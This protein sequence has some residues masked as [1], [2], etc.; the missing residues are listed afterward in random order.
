MTGLAAAAVSAALILWLCLGDPKRRRALRIAGEGHG[1]STRRLIAAAACLPGLACAASGDAA[2][3]LI[4]LGGSGAADVN[5]VLPQLGVQ[6]AAVAVVAV[7]SA[8]FTWILA[9]AAAL[10]LPMRVTA[11]AEH[12]GLDI[13]HHGE[14]A[15]EFD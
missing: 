9:K 12:D 14:R 7:W 4:W 11:E 15:Y 8:V 3:F 13:S 5:G 1:T 6:A 2:A 10:V